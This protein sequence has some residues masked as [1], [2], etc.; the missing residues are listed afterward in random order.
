MLQTLMTKR[1]TVRDA[2]ITEKDGAEYDI[3]FSPTKSKLL[4]RRSWSV[5]DGQDNDRSV[6]LGSGHRGRGLQG[7][8]INCGAKRQVI[9]QLAPAGHVL[10]TPQG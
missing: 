3:E 5:G 10:A 2:E 8:A 9:A 4:K 1:C 6:H 7:R